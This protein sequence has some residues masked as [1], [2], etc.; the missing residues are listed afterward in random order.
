MCY[1][2]NVGDSRALMSSEGGKYNF[3]LSTDHKPDD[4]EEKRRITT[5]GG[6][7]YQYDFYFPFNATIQDV[8]SC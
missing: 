3:V 6:S 1:V 7:I 5:N 8:N 4:Q 2:A